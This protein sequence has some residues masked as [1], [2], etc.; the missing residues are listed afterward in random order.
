MA[1]CFDNGLIR[2][3]HVLVTAPGQHNAALVMHPDRQFSR[4]ARL[5]HARLAGQESDVPLPRC[6][7]LPQLGQPV[8]LCVAPDEDPADVGQQR[9]HGNGRRRGRLPFDPPRRHRRGHTLELQAA[10]RNERRR[11]LNTTQPADD[12]GG[13]NLTAERRPAQP[14]RLDHRRAVHVVV[15][16]TDIAGRQAHPDRERHR[17]LAGPV[18]PVDRL[19]DRHRRRHRVRRSGEGGHDPIA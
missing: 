9:R 14:R 12:L 3:A 4:Q 8:Q 10:H 7:L 16:E 5:A 19:L 15:L 1:K 11:T 2:D 17:R 6:R 13:Q 18:E